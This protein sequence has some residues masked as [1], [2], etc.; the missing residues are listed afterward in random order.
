MTSLKWISLLIM[1]VQNAAT[2]IIFRLS[3]T[4]ADA[5]NSYNKLVSVIAAEALKLVA[6]LIL[7]VMEEGWD[8]G[9][10]IKVV[11]EMIVG[12]PY[13]TALLAVPATLYFIQ[14]NL[15]QMASSNLPA[16]T[17]QVTYQG[18]TLV[19]ALMSIL[20]LQKRL[21]RSKW[22]AIS[23]MAAG[24]ALVQLAKAEEKKQASMANAKEQNVSFG[25]LLVFFGCL[26][27]GF[28]GVYFERLMKKP[29]A[30]AGGIAPKKPSMWVKN[31]QLALLSCIIGSLIVL[32]SGTAKDED[33]RSKP[34]LHGFTQPV[35]IMVV[36]NALGGLCV[37][38]V[39]K[40]ADNILKGFACAIA[41]VLATLASVYFFGFTLKPLFFIGMFIVLGSTFL[42]GGT[43]K[44]SGPW[45]N[46][47][48]ELC[49]GLRKAAD[50]GSM[51]DD[52]AGG[53]PT[54]NKELQS[55]S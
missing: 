44:L 26:C 24:I 5:K 35:W 14:N 46:S 23:L 54:T 22:L 37:A 17:F 48:P 50:D 30:G 32:A 13:D 15:L 47:E 11:Q 36:N 34:Y 27:S 4:G 31:V 42:Y 8:V 16:A 29:T 7:I 18:K 20:L 45:W 6:S 28:A 38:F 43:F 10:G 1:M 12:R 2:P 19:V 55:R 21:T 40:H 53:L 41:T 51:S 3:T 49:E 9:R 39:I 52:S 33:G 25:L